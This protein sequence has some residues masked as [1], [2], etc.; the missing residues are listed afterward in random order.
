MTVMLRRFVSPLMPLIL[1]LAS[2][3][4]QAAET[5]LDAVSIDASLVV[6]LKNPKTTIGKF[7]DL[8]DLVVKK[9][10]D[11]IRENSADLGQMIS[12]PTLAG[13]D[14]ESDWWLA[15]YA[16]GGEEKA[17]VV[18]IVPASDM[19][20]MKE[21]LGE[22]VKFMES[23]K[24]GVYTTDDDA[25]TKTAARLK[26]EGK[27]ISTLIDKPSST[28]FEGGDVS[29]FINVT[30]LAAAYKSQID[31]AKDKFTETLENAPNNVPGSAPG[32]DPKQIT[33]IAGQVMDV[34]RQGLN[35]TLSCTIAAT[36][37]KEGVSFEDLVRVKSGT[38]TDKLLAKSAPG[39]LGALSLLP[40]GSL[41]YFGLDWDMSDFTKISRWLVGAGAIKPEAAQDFE[42]TLKE[43]EKLKLESVVS[44]FGLGDVEGGA[45]RSVTVT[46]VDNPTKMRELS[47]KLMKAMGTVENQGIKQTFTV[48]PD[49]EK[50][51]KNS[52]D[53]VTVKT[54][55]EEA[56]DPITGMMQ[57]MQSGMFGPDGMVSRVVYLKDR[58]VQTIGGGKQ[59]MTDVLAALD[60][61]STESSKSP[62]QQTRGKLGQKSNLV[63]LLDL[64]NTIAKI[65]SIVVESQ[66]LPPVFPIDPDAVKDLQS[67]ASYLGVS[68][69]TEAQA[70]RVKT[71]VPVEQ[72]QGIAKI[73]QFVQQAM[74][75]GA[76]AE[77]ETEE[78]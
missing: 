15:V 63:I 46:E 30:Q 17:D 12:N 64:S 59:S 72:M 41:L 77:V 37:S 10:G 32:L 34:L 25:A 23:G 3:P 20:A 21:A 40:G 39:P 35:D 45:V 49:A 9:S 69:S 16:S 56:Q 44:S 18:F 73:V 60:K 43:V 13:V 62:V 48:K 68:A 28:L 2:L 7:A 5:A 22:S 27:S 75:G 51:G 61:K 31:E 47:Q 71:H 74:G 76:G 8:A 70:V 42:S 19:K 78:N 66:V 33:E 52:A 58:V 26:G 4:V 54:E 57:R 29:V 6:R 14:M 53:L 24:F 50:Y 67:K 65:F 36:V 38:P 55:F 1:V 11:K